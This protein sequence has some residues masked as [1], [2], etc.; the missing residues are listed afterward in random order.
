MFRMA[1]LRK[2]ARLQPGKALAVQG[3]D[4]GLLHAALDD[5]VHPAV[6]R[7]LPYAGRGWGAQRGSACMATLAQPVSSAVALDL[8][9]DNDA[10]LWP[11]GLVGW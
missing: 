1:P 11:E 6:T 9:V 10:E 3:S 5:W 8:I 4:S 2:T 7:H